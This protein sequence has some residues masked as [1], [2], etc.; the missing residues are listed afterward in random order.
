MEVS[1]LPRIEVPLSFG[2]AYIR[3]NTCSS[4]G[5]FIRPREVEML[6]FGMMFGLATPP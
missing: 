4:G 1:S 6:V 2:G 3:L 5:R